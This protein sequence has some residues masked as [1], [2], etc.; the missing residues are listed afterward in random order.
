MQMCIMKEVD[1]PGFN[2]YS[3]ILMEDTHSTKIMIH[4]KTLFYDGVQSS[5]AHLYFEVT[6]AAISMIL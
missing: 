1:H 4:L 5:L 6:L 2:D 3:I